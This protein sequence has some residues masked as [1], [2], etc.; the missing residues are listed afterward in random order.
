[1]S[2]S[3][4][5]K[6]LSRLA[7]QANR[8]AVL[9]RPLYIVPARTNLCPPSS[10]GL[11]K[12]NPPV[13]SPTPRAPSVHTELNRLASYALQFGF[14][15]P[16]NKDFFLQKEFLVLRPSKAVEQKQKDT[17]IACLKELNRLA[18]LVELSSS[19][20]KMPPVYPVFTPAYEF[21]QKNQ[22]GK[23]F[24]SPF[25]FRLRKELKLLP[26]QSFQDAFPNTSV[27]KIEMLANRPIVLKEKFSA[28]LKLKLDASRNVFH[29][30]T[31]PASFPRMVTNW[32]HSLLRSHALKKKQTPA[33]KK[34]KVSKVSQQKT[35]NLEP[36]TL[37]DKFA[38]ATSPP[39]D[40]AQ[41][42]VTSPS[43]PSPRS[44]QQ[45]RVTEF[46]FSKLT[47]SLSSRPDNSRCL[48]IED[49]AQ[50]LNI[51]LN[52]IPSDLHPSELYSMTKEIAKTNCAISLGIP[53]TEDAIIRMLSALVLLS[54]HLGLKRLSTTPD[55]TQ[56]PCLLSMIKFSTVINSG[57][58][59]SSVSSILAKLKQLT[60]PI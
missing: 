15:Y 41:A 43:S 34:K 24:T 52:V 29:I 51:D 48:T 59:P 58:D 26:S 46:D 38:P 25:A 11:E 42:E 37:A 17:D 1:M 53:T 2:P 39:E 18:R 45:E 10:K 21:R 33:P 14:V 47:F 31:T 6:T 50:F 49:A 28:L 16:E 8:F 56:L 13:A 54:H 20:D 32:I 7:H 19:R 12:C 57:P 22:Y 27:P 3:P 23:N 9:D 60:S 35:N 4:E 40:H 5:M 36:T 55:L 30:N 44:D